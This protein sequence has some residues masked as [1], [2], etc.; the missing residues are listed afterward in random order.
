MTLLSSSLDMMSS[1][2]TVVE[3]ERRDRL[4]LPQQYRRKHSDT[5]RFLRQYS[6]N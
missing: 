3:E 2:L 4:S 1:S 5:P 6:K